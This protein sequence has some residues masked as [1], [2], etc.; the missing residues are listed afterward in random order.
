[1][2]AILSPFHQYKR[3]H[4]GDPALEP[5]DNS[6]DEPEDEVGDEVSECT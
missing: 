5:Q 6:E 2:Q 4:D 3:R 1:L